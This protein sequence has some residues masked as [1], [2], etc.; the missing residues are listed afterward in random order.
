VRHR[1]T[2]D[3]GT[4]GVQAFEQLLDEIADDVL[5]RPRDAEP[6]PG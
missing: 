1:A 4:D 6:P 5:E 3:P 2:W